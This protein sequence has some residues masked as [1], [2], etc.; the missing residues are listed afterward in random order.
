MSTHVERPY[1]VA[2]AALLYKRKPNTIR[3]LCLEHGIGICYDRRIRRLS[4]AELG[5]IGIIL[6][7]R[8]RK[9]RAAYLPT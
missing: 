8:N 7:K 4:R 1:T 6:A 2:D 3:K 9:P 5:E